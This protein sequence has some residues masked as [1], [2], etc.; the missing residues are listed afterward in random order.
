MNQIE[1]VEFLKE[2][3]YLNYCADFHQLYKIHKIEEAME[4]S[5]EGKGLINSNF[6]E[7]VL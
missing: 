6:S 3:G 7:I 1:K 5:E 2:K 4:K